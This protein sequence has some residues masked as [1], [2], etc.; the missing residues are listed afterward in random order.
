MACIPAF[1]EMGE[2]RAHDAKVATFLPLLPGAIY[3][4][5]RPYNN[6]EW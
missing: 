2:A 5:D 4:F 6:Y 3:V 1:L